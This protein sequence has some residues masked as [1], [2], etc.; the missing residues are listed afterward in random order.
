[1]TAR[2]PVIVLACAA[3][4]DN[5]APHDDLFTPVSGAR[6]ALQKYRYD[7]GT[8][9]A[10]AGELYDTELHVRCTPQ[11]AAD[12]ALRCVPVADDAAYLDPACTARVGLGRT[13]ARP[14][15]F[16]V[17]EDRPEGSVAR[18][19]RAG[20]AIAPI[21]QYYLASAAGCA[22]PTP[23]PPELT[24]FFEV[25][26]EVESG[27]L[28]AFHDGELG[29]GRLGLVVRQTDD[30]ARVAIGMRDH[31]LGVACAPRLQADGSAA[32]EPLAAQPVTG[33]SD[34]ACRELAV[35]VDAG[36]PPALV[37]AVEP[38]G[39]ASY[40]ALGLELSTPLY[41]R[42]GDACTAVAT[43]A[44][45]RVFSVDAALALAALGRA[46]EDAPRRRLRRIV[47]TRDDLRFADDR[48]FDSAAGADCEHRTLRS[49]IRCVPVN[50]AT[51]TTLYADDCATQLRVAEVPHQ[52]CE[53]LAYATSNRPFQIRAL[54]APV[55][56]ALFQLDG[57]GCH[58][59]AP[60]PG[61]ELRELGPPLDPATFV[62]AIYYSERAQ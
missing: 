23:V 60:A 28:V 39:C 31:E 59:Y 26:D 17:H 44:G 19:F 2:W 20:A 50:V 16:V 40:H 38:S 37:K 25:G 10:V 27:A 30:G 32:C 49:V 52:T 3:C 61:N 1:M 43:P 62:G 34:P 55:A 54:G 13:I 24:S 47:L 12:G 57:S 42:D 56:A 41:R 7:D 48:L 11:L 46:P 29:A 35:A 4:G 22:G 6:L 21:T 8:E 18:V 58:P 36:A 33:F 45:G 15:H 9:Q 53:P 14:T 5:L 51:A